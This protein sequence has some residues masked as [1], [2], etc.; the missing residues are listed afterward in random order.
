MSEFIAGAPF[1]AV[2]PRFATD[3]RSVPAPGTVDWL[4]QVVERHS[5][6]EEGALEQYAELGAAS[7]DLV[8]ALVMRLILEDEERHHGLLKRIGASLRDAIEWT[9]SPNALPESGSPQQPLTPGLAEAARALIEE[10]RAGAH[11]LR[12]LARLEKGIGGDLH[13]LLLEMMAT[14]SDKHARMLQFVRDRLVTRARAAD[15]PCD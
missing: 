11:Q 1:A 12:E 8:I 14:D 5:S 15:G 9:H 2:G 10:E 6:A 7:G 13:S 3:M 4:L